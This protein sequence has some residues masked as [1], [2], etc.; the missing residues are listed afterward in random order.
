[1]LVQYPVRYLEVA[2][3]LT[4][5]QLPVLVMKLQTCSIF[6]HRFFELKPEDKDLLFRRA[7]NAKILTDTLLRKLL[8]E[9]GLTNFFSRHILPTASNTPV[10]C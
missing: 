3:G 5:A 7:G 1:M 4:L 9:K 8:R 10:V 2:A 6:L